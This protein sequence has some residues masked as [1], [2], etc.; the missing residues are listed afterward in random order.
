MVIWVM[1]LTGINTSNLLDGFEGVL[2]IDLNQAERTIQGHLY[3][4]RHFL[5]AVGKDP[6]QVSV[7][8]IRSYLATFQDKS[9]S[10]SLSNGSIAI[11]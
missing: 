8:D 11:F 2:R 6:R 10:T 3:L 1:V 5:K 4:I 7:E 9:A